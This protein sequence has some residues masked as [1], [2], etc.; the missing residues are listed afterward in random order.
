V[1]SKYLKKERKG[2]MVGMSV[3]WVT[4]GIVYAAAF[5][6]A[7]P[8]AWCA[9][10]VYLQ[11]NLV[12][13]IP[14]LAQSTDPNLK[15]PWGDSFSATSPFWAAN[16]GSN[17]STLYSGTGS[18][19]SSRVVSV[20]GGPTGTIAN[21]VATDFIEANGRSASFVFST[22]NGSIYAWNS[23]NTAAVQAA[24]VAG[25]SF[26]GLALAN[27]GSG[28]YLYAANDAGSGSIEVFSSTFAQV[29]LAGS[30]KDPNLPASVAFG[31]TYVPYNIQN[32]NGQLYVEY[33]NFKTGAGA[34]SIF[35][36]NGNFLKELITA[37]TPQLN[38]PWGV[39]IAPAGF[40]TFANDLLVGNFGDGKINAFDPNTGAFL[41]TVSGFNGPLVNS[42]LWS[43]AVRTGGTFNTSAV[44]F[45]AGINNQADGLFG[46]ITAVTPSTVAITNSPSLPA[47][48][49]GT[50]YAQ[51][52]TPTGGTPPYANWT[53]ATGSLP[54]G[55]TLN[56]TTGALSGTPVAIGGTFNFTV[57][58]TDSTGA[59]GSGSFQ[60]TVQPPAT[61]TPLT[62][63]GSF[64]QL[65][66]GGGWK[67]SMTLINL[68]ANTVNAQIN[69]Y[70]D[71]GTASTLPVT[72]PQ[73]GSSSAMSS[74]SV[75]VGPND[76]V[77]IQSGGSTGPVGLGWA[78]V[79]AAGTGALSGYLTFEA[80]SPLDSQGTV[81]L[82]SRLSTSLLMPFDNTNGYQTGFALANQS[83]AAQT[84][85]VTLLDQNG[86]QLSSSPVNLPAYGHASFFLSTQFSK[87]AN[88]L[89]IIQLQGAAGV[90]G[91]GLRFSPQ[92]SFTSIPIIR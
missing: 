68:S 63:I 82:D 64:A 75:T 80:S 54:P 12:S 9:N 27:N 49:V 73:Y 77:V 48:K 65:A 22:L 21:G 3:R 46:A 23:L 11:T 91:V 92:G 10:T 17:T 47:G 15:N 41:G 43:L 30:F 26:T 51:T 1:G 18:T 66:S 34:V 83:S 32:I 28:N 78:D 8:V 69:L 74:M 33:A 37:G 35:D 20:P 70:A 5:L 25:A 90:T 4:V 67:T 39:V 71:N 89:G 40:G 81:P 6:L 79:L 60:L 76:S 7:Q 13:D 38:L 36:A 87:S 84:I 42:G 86:L 88:Q 31:S 19:V 57:T 58:M 44:Y 53:V 45:M 62:R 85:T 52:L 24:T 61:S 72:F 2:I 55:L 56:S 14:G 29:T 50:A 16:A 59:M